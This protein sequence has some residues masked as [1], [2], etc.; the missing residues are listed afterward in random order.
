MQPGDHPPF[1]TVVWVRLDAQQPMKAT[2]LT[3]GTFSTVDPY[4][5]FF[6][7]TNFYAPWWAIQSWRLV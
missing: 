1:G 7:D 4:F 2:I 5:Q 6:D 3:S